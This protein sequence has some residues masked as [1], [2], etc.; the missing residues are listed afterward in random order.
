MIDARDE[1]ASAALHEQLLRLLESVN[2][3]LQF[4]ETKNT[5]GLTLGSAALAVLAQ[6]MTGYST[7]WSDWAAVGLGASIV[8]LIGSVAAATASFLPRT[9]IERQR[10]IRPPSTG[11]NLLFYGH[12]AEYDHRELLRAIAD[13]YL[14][15][16]NAQ[17]DRFADDLALQIVANASITVRKLR[18][19][20][21]SVLLFALGT[22]IGLISAAIGRQR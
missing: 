15:R 18:L 17:P 20:R 8:L 21:W 10:T 14:G 12:L 13:R 19:F 3:W 4:A 2:G 5:T 9:A 22:V 6:F 11:D 1:A 7:V 16:P